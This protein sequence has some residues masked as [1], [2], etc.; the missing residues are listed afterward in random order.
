[1]QKMETHVYLVAAIRKKTATRSV[2]HL[3]PKF[4]LKPYLRGLSQTCFLLCFFTYN[5]YAPC[6][7]S[8]KKCWYSSQNVSTEIEYK[9]ASFG[10]LLQTSPRERREK[11]RKGGTEGCCFFELIEIQNPS[12][13]EISLVYL[14]SE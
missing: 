7:S 1:M 3:F 10:D 14:A 8:W 5:Q 9:W 4:Y 2:S 6:S 12:S 13:F 11:R